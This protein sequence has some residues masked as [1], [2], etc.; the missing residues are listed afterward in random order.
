MYKKECTKEKRPLGFVNT[1]TFA[2][3]S[4]GQEVGTLYVQLPEEIRSSWKEKLDI[5]AFISI[6]ATGSISAEIAVKGKES[7]DLSTHP[8]YH[9]RILGILQHLLKTGF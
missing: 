3:L 5:P 8:D 7:Q 4:K 2:Q 6:S 1:D 9:K